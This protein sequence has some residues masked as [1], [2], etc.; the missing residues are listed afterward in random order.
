M[1]LTVLG[2]VDCLFHIQRALTQRGGG[3]AWLSPYFH[4]D[5]T[6]W[7]ALALQAAARPTHMAKIV[8]REP[9]HLGFCNNSGIGEG[10]VWINPAR[11]G[12][13]LI[14]WH[15]QSLDIIV[16]LVSSKDL[17]GTITNSDLE[18]SALVIY[19]ANHLAAVPEAC[20][21]VPCSRLDNN[22][23]VSW[24]TC[25]ASTINLVVMDLLCIH[26]LYSIF[27]S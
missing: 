2:A 3:Q 25:K 14:W 4:R 21:A 6:D 5:I 16:D 20:M 24:S 13:N 12:H 10:G 19:E 27:F 11:T 1:H 18:T 26:A 9:T 17:K 23:I 7:R 15:P 8:H 22:P